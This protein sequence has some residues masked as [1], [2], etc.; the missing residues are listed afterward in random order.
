MRLLVVIACVLAGNQFYCSAPPT[1]VVFES[2][3]GTT[4]RVVVASGPVPIT[5]WSPSCGISRLIV[6]PDSGAS[7]LWT[8]YGN[9]GS[10]D[11]PIHSGVRYGQTPDDARTVA[12]PERLQRGVTY[13]VELSR[14]TC[15]Q[16]SPCSLV[17]V[18]NARFQP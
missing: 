18:G 16:G 6:Y 11:N 14:L 9:A 12:G 15:D 13:R 1:A 10:S 4:V 7:A 3:S 5:S 8:V 2:C 17:P